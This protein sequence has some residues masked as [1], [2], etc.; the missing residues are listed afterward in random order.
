TR[1]PPTPVPSSHRELP[2]S[3]HCGTAMNARA[4]RELRRRGQLRQEPPDYGGRDACGALCAAR[5]PRA[6]PLDQ[7]GPGDHSL[8]RTSVPLANR[9]CSRRCDGGTMTGLDDHFVPGAITRCGVALPHYP[10]PDGV[11]P[12]LDS[13]GYKSTVLRHPKEPL[14]P[15]PQRLNELTGPALGEDIVREGD[16]DLTT[17]HGGDAGPQGQRTIAHGR[18]LQ[19]GGRPV[20]HA[21]VEAWQATAAGRYAPPPDT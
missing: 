20:P 5:R 4:H 1:I 2:C 18:V 21:L 15:L 8:S 11:H 7:R 17:Y 19:E 10:V 16:N 3:S 6:P 14:V 9:A 13:P 12:P